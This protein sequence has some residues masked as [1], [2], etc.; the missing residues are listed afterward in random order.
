[1]V[2]LFIEAVLRTVKLLEAEGRHAKRQVARLS[3]AIVLYAVAGAVLFVAALMMAGAIVLALMM[4]MPA[5]GAVAISAA[6]LLI[7]AGVCALI[8]RS[9]RQG[10]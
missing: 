5:A 8:A 9:L 4:V 3:V 2:R 6:V 7:G 1:M 10:H